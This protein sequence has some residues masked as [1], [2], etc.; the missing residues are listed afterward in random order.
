MGK[1]K[2][3]WILK[4]HYDLNNDLVS[5]HF[6]IKWWDKFKHD[7]IISQVN[8]EFPLARAKLQ[9]PTES[10]TSIS[11]LPVEGKSR[12]ELKEL[13]RHLMLQVSQMGAD[14][15]EDD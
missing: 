6:S 3:P 13:A 7:R 5:R 2:V 1:Y 9:K 15:E 10:S 12:A 11:S 8:V 14:E 4:W